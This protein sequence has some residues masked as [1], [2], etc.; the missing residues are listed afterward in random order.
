MQFLAPTMH[1]GIAVYY[2]E[3]LTTA[4]MVCFACIW[5]AVIV[6]SSDALRQKKGARA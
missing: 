1:F 5:S 6:F 2:G 4:H 3:V